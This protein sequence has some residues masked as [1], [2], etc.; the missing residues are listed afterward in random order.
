MPLTLDLDAKGTVAPSATLKREQR[1]KRA[2]TI[3][4]WRT[5][6]EWEEMYKR[7]Y[8]IYTPCLTGQC[9]PTLCLTWKPS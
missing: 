8:I 1:H 7:R 3:P 2:E 4:D 9:S 6:L 5:T